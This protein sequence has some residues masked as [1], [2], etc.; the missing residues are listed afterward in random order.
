MR[1][2]ITKLPKPK[3]QSSKNQRK[4]YMMGRNKG[5]SWQIFFFFQQKQY[6][7]E[8]NNVFK[9]QESKTLHQS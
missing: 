5:K 4:R 9:I 8:E 7:L 6:R 2:S 1:L 3:I